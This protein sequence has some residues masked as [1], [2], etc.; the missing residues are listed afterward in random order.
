MTAMF[1][2]KLTDGK[3][4]ETEIAFNTRR[5]YCMFR[6]EHIG[7]KTT[8]I[9]FINWCEKQI[10]IESFPLTKKPNRASVTR[11]FN[12]WK[13]DESAVSFIIN[14]LQERLSKS[15]DK[16]KMSMLDLIIEDLE[17]IQDLYSERRVISISDFTNP[18]DYFH[19]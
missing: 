1:K 14:E 19:C 12:K 2:S 8:K 10:G 17:Y 15:E 11:W 13:Y 7:E 5:A 6:A 18:K 9:Q 16:Y 3:S 4:T